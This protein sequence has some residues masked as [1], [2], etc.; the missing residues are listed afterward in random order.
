VIAAILLDSFVEYEPLYTPE[1]FAATVLNSR[2]TVARL[3]EGPVWLAFSDS[4]VVG[5]ISVV[6]K[7]ESLYV[8]GM[9]VLPAA[10]G[11]G[12]GQLLLGHAEKYARAKGCNRLFLSSTPF[13]TEAIRLY[14]RSGYVR[15]DDGPHDLFGTPLFTMEKILSA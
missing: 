2:E 10:R 11:R 12:L 13:L 9:A 4:Q 8:R 14:E 6:L 1:G 7:D 15:I 5:T 3:A